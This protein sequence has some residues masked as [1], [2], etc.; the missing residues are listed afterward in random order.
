M[1]RGLEEDASQVKVDQVRDL[2]E[3]LALKSY[4][5]G[6]KVGV[7]ESAETLN[8]SGANA[9]L[10]T[11]EEPGA[12]TL[13]IM[14]ARPTH[15]LPATIASRCL[16][17][18]LAPPATESALAWLGANGGA[19]PQGE[20]WDAALGLA[21]GAPLRAVE[22]QNAGVAALDADM[23]QSLAQLAAGAV[24][25]TLL[26]ERWI[27]TDPQL[28]IMWLENWVTQRVHAALGAAS[29]RQIAEPV[30]LPATLLKAKIRSLF[31]LLD[32]ARQ[33]RLLAPTGMNHQLALEAMLLD[34]RAALGE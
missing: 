17:L 28:R 2:I 31:E 4:R 34:G 8:N 22:L 33:L 3:A 11:L 15:R 20:T 25:V 7:I 27:K 5:G 23:R 12:D 14:M 19:L 1:S 24:D 29:S 32:A 9:F 18:P 21:G 6:Y 10:K 13:L 16:R 26:A 30:R